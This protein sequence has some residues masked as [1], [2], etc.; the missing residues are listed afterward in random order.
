MSYLTLCEIIVC[1]SHCH[2]NHFAD[3]TRWWG[4]SHSSTTASAFCFRVF[5]NPW[6]G[7]WNKST[8]P[9]LR[10]NCHVWRR[11]TLGSWVLVN[12]VNSLSECPGWS[13][14][15]WFTGRELCPGQPF[16]ES[17]SWSLGSWTKRI[18]QHEMSMFWWLKET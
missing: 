4:L 16:S 15:Q 14:P 9:S 11:Y 5:S 2:G 10:D 7:V 8:G 17:D 1:F 3:E 12:W 6:V 13:R 18:Y